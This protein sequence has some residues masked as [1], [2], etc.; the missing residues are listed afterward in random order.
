MKKWILSLVSMLLAVGLLA[1]CSD[2]EENEADAPVDTVEQNTEKTTTEENE[3]QVVITVSENNGEEVHSE[4]AVSIE[5]GD[6]LLDVM[7]DNFDVEHDD[8]FV[9]SINGV[10][11]EESEQRAWMY[12][13]NDEMPMVGAAEYELEPGD[14]VVFDLQEWE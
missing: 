14:E 1:G 10:A 12:Y 9:T 11:P 8:G 6:L 13:V 7:E 5:E 3:E 4:E 2:K